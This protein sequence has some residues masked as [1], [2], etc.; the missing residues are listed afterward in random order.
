MISLVK[1]I[2]S[3]T[4]KTVISILL[5]LGLSTLFRKVCEGRNCFVFKHPDIEDIHKSTYQY[6]NKCYNFKEKAVK[7]NQNKKIVD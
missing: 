7:C 3:K 4:G 2:E 1:I 6:N 5:G